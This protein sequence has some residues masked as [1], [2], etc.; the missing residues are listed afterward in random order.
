MR[1]SP[2]PFPGFEGLEEIEQKAIAIF[3]AFISPDFDPD[4]IEEANTAEKDI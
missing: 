2:E 4:N 3:M 1:E